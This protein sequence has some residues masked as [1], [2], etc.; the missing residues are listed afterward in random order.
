MNGASPRVGREIRR[1][2]AVLGVIIL[3][4]TVKVRAQSVD[5]GEID[6]NIHGFL[7][8]VDRDD[9]DASL[10]AISSLSIYIHT[11][12]HV[13]MRSS[14][15]DGITDNR[16]LWDEIVQHLVT[17]YNKLEAKRVD[18]RAQQARER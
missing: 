1:T 12:E 15:S 8:D 9:L 17:R 4:I 5:P 10:K 16:R 11:R 13:A 2:T 6:R 7:A 14:T 3:S 18:R